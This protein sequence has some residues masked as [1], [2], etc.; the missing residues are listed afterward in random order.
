MRDISTELSHFSDSNMAIVEQT[1]ASMNQ[2]NEAITS[3]T[4]ILATMTERS[5]ALM[6]MNSKNN[7]QLGDMGL[8]RDEVV[9]KTDHMIGKMVALG[10][11]SDKVDLIV[12]TVG[13]IADQTNLLA[14]N[15]SIE[16]AR[17]GEHGRGFAVV[18]DE[19]R[20]LAEDT[21]ENLVEMT[22]FTQIIRNSTKDIGVSVKETRSA[23]SHMSDKIEQVNR[24]FQASVESLDVTMGGVMDVSSMMEE[25]NAASDDV[26]QAMS[27][28][29]SDSEKM[30]VMIGNLHQHANQAMA[31]SSEIS[32]IDEAM[33]AITQE[34]VST[35]NKGTT[36]IT[37]DDLISILGDAIAAHKAWTQKLKQIVDSQTLEPIQSDG[38]KCEFGHYYNAIKIEN[39]TLKSDWAA[40]EHIHKELHEKSNGVSRAIRNGDINRSRKIYHEAE[41]LSSQILGIFETIIKKIKMISGQDEKVFTR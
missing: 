2:V 27:A 16:A 32:A 29:A 20:K 5:A 38:D 14:L 30:N 3:S 36:P 21:Q 31:Y 19:I 25:V 28:V 40:I 34:L 11:I 8:I 18:A 10:E 33:S 37:N 6:E 12:K 22:N 26:N 24:T 17:A 39:K 1:T 7:S 4:Q 15:A 13:T 9:E 23:M 41:K 35:L